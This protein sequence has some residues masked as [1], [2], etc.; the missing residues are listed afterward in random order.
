MVGL[1]FGVHNGKKHENVFILETMVGHRLGEFA[2]LGYLKDMLKKEKSLK[3]M[4][5]QVD[6]KNNI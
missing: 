5:V 6:L 4:V 3:Y 1:T 2:K